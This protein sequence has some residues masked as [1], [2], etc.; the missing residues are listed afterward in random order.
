[1]QFP[2]SDW[3]ISLQSFK[4]HI[5]LVRLLVFQQERTI[6][7]GEITELGEAWSYESQLF[8]KLLHS[9]DDTSATFKIHV[10]QGDPN[11]N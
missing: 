4:L 2:Q 5:F 10:G 6:M 1:M 3:E 7:T 11:T 9:Q 8:H